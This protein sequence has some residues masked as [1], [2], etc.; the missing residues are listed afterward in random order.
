M[1][2]LAPQTS[3]MA[4]QESDPAVETQGCLEK[5]DVG[6]S[7]G[8][9]VPAAPPQGPEIQLDTQQVLEGEAGKRGAPQGGAGSEAQALRQ[10]GPEQKRGASEL[11]LCVL[12]EEQETP[13]ERSDLPTPGTED[14]GHEGRLEGDVREPAPQQ[15]EQKLEGAPGAQ[16]W[17]GLIPGEVLAGGTPEQEALREEVVRLRTEV[18]ALRAELQAQARRLEARVVEAARF[19]EELAQAQRAE[20]EAHQEAEAQAQEQA[21][22]REAVEAAGRELEAVLRERE[23]LAEALAAAGRERRQWEREGPRLRARAEAAEER[24]QELERQGRDCQEEV[25]RQRQEKQA[26]SEVGTSGSGLGRKSGVPG[27][28][29]GL[30]GVDS[31][32][33][34]A[35]P[36]LPSQDTAGGCCQRRGGCRRG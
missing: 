26:L 15:L 2:A 6:V 11:D 17:E 32:E 30:G 4:A 29:L 22:L 28:L 27:S 18:V 21:R 20:A 3:D 10:E 7:L 5:A 23:A 31:T 12:L 9:P 35:G 24:A 19:S 8:R 36:P 1:A 34:P 25:E 14:R 16:A 13:G 33:C